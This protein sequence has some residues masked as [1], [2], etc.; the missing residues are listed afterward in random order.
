MSAIRAGKARTVQSVS[1][2]QCCGVLITTHVIK[3][4]SATI[5]QETSAVNAIRAGKGRTARLISIVQCFD[6]F[7]IIHEVTMDSVRTVMEVHL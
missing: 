1:I 7:I 6:I 4:D 5:C 3:M 2:L